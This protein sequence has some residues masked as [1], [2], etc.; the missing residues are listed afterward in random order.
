[1]C[2]GAAESTVVELR[3]EYTAVDAEHLA[4]ESSDEGGSRSDGPMS[5]HAAGRRRLQ[6]QSFGGFQAVTTVAAVEENMSPEGFG[7]DAVSCLPFGFA[8]VRRANRCR[9][10]SISRSEAST[11][12]VVLVP[13][14]RARVCQLSAPFCV[15]A[16][17]VCEASH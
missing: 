17:L 12:V 11:H 14:F 10:H 3:K 2:H 7:G 16:V 13:V 4:E 6:T 15:K 8:F 1:M 5:P 9:T